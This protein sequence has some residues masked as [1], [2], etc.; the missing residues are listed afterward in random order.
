MIDVIFTHPGGRGW[1]PIQRLAHLAAHELGGDLFELRLD[2]SYSRF[3]KLRAVAPHLR[4]GHRHCVIVAP[5]PANLVAALQR[6]AVLRRY[7]TV[8]GWVIDSFWDDRI[9]HVARASSVFDHLWVT[10]DRDQPAWAS[11]VRC[12]VEVAPWGTDALGACDTSAAS[13]RNAEPRSVDLLRV[14]RQPSAWDDDQASERLA[15]E[16]GLTFAG[17]P[18]F[19]PDEESSDRNLR[20]ALTRTKFVLA[21]SNKVNPTDYTHPTKEYLTGRWTDALAHGASV[22]G[23]VPQ[24]QTT[25]RLL[26]P[27]ATTEISPSDQ[28]LGMEELAEAVQGWTPADAQRNRVLALR[29][30]DWRHRLDVISSTLGI[31]PPTL[32]A[33]L[34]RVEQMAK[35]LDAGMEKPST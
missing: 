4:G 12:S 13:T 32:E 23:A 1:G 5:Q 15:A 14:G 22:A 7:A 33:S 6:P 27:G 35:S 16:F 25:Q 31:H 19:G 29:R 24:T 18:P 8:S 2:R 34:H 11:K 3:L 20:S 21:F 17:R 10:E 28:R 30:L 9:P 26:W